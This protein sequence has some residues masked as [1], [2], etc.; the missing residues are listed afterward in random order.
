MIY[1]RGGRYRT[2]VD[3]IPSVGLGDI[4]NRDGGHG[5]VAVR[6]CCVCV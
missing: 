6:V 5:F 3:S 2:S 4:P 1:S